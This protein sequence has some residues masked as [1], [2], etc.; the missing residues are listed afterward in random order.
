MIVEDDAV[1]IVDET[2]TPEL[3]RRVID[4]VMDGVEIDGRPWL[5]DLSMER[6]CPTCTACSTPGQ[7]QTRKTLAI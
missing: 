2:D 1:K 6:T 3:M 4:F 7:R 5:T